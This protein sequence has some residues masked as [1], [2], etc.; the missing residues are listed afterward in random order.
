MTFQERIMYLSLAVF[1]MTYAAIM[2]IWVRAVN[3]RVDKII[4]KE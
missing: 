4:S 2:Q 3:V 1:L